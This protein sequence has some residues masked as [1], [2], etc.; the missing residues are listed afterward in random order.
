MLDRRQERGVLAD[1][2]VAKA[3]RQVGLLEGLR[4]S[5]GCA[6]GELAGREKAAKG[7]VVVLGHCVA[8]TDAGEIAAE[9]AAGPKELLCTVLAAGRTVMLLSAEVAGRVVL[10]VLGV[11]AEVESCAARE[12]CRMSAGSAGPV[13]ESLLV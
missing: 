7:A 11:A 13:R 10:A 1:G 3:A 6:V 5:A 4:E 8:E 12:L 2:A 9:L